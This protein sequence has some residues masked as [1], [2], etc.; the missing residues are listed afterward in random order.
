MN[1]KTLSLNSAFLAVLFSMNA[2]ASLP[3]GIASGDVTQNSAVL[4]SR[5]DTSGRLSFEY[6]KDEAFMNII[7]AINADVTEPL[8]P[9][10]ITI[11][12][13]DANTRYYYRVTDSTEASLTGTFLL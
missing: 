8:Q 13:L 11:T 1:I 7:D 9:V 2:L 10:K 12:Q 3:N 6:S 4:W 5:S